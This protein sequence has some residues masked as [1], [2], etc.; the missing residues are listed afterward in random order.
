MTHRNCSSLTFS[1]FISWVRSMT[2]VNVISGFH[3]LEYF[4][5]TAKPWHLLPPSPPPKPWFDP[6]SLAERTG[7]QYIPL[8]SPARRCQET[9]QPASFTT[10]EFIRLQCRFEEG[11]NL[12][13]DPRHNNGLRCIIQIPI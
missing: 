11:Y 13:I 4:L 2:M 7:L 1:S 9:P 5:S 12:S 3:P 8:Y 10:E 6:A